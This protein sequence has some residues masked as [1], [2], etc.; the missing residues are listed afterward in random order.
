MKLLRLTFL[1][2]CLSRGAGLLRDETAV[3]SLEYVLAALAVALGAIAATRTMANL[4]TD[5]LR[6][7]YLVVNL[8]VP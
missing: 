3:T 1:S 2:G 4:L 5:Y 7:V 6:R 8:P